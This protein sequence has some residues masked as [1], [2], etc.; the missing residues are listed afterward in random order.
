MSTPSNPD[1]PGEADTRESP[2]GKN[3]KGV[4]LGASHAFNFTQK[5][6]FFFF[7]VF[8]CLALFGA[9]AI[10]HIPLQNITSNQGSHFPHGHSDR[11]PPCRWAGSPR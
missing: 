11:S 6:F 5:V 2:F 10:H 4:W 1:S 7:L 9:S 3:R 8:S